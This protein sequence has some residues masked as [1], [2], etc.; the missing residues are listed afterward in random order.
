MIEGNKKSD[1][2]ALQEIEKWYLTDHLYY[3]EKG[4]YLYR[5]GKQK[6]ANLIE[7][8]STVSPEDNDYA[9]SFPLTVPK[10]KLNSE[11]NN[12]YLVEVK[13]EQ[14][15]GM[16]L[17][18]STVRFYPKRFN[19]DTNLI[20]EKTLEKYGEYGHIDEL[21][22]VSN[23]YSQLFDIV[24]VHPNGLLEIRIDNPQMGDGKLAPGNE[25][26]QAFTNLQKQFR[27]LV[28][29]TS[30]VDFELL[31]GVNLIDT[32]DDIYHAG[33]SEGFVR[34]LAFT[35]P[36]SGSKTV[37][38]DPTLPKDCCRKD[39]YHKGGSKAVKDD[40]NAYRMH[41][42]WGEEESGPGELRVLGTV[43]NL[44]N[45]EKPFHEA[46]ITRTVH[47]GHYDFIYTRMLKYINER[48]EKNTLSG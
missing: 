41:I 3:G 1:L 27:K 16:T 36:N 2:E 32:L 20:D 39:S 35:T 22:V 21:T 5:I 24:V 7:I 37:R 48:Y 11:D 17:V 46:I 44:D 19:I 31:G 25:R 4:V 14:D 33:E 9:K 29:K 8:L 12:S 15:G 42:T 10:D 34:L 45:T 47:H 28:K 40:I 26:R 18:F 13:S 43:Y 6:A 30:G 38:A 23:Q